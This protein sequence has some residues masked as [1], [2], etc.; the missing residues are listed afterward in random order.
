[1]IRELRASLENQ[2]ALDQ[3]VLQECKAMMVLQVQRG[4]KVILVLQECQ[5]QTV[6]QGQKDTPDLEEHQVKLVRTEDLD[7]WDHLGLQDL[8]VPP[9]SKVTQV[10]QAPLVLQA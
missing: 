5:G 2:V 1:M 7:Q 10:I 9:G 6:P 8:Q 3:L 4:H